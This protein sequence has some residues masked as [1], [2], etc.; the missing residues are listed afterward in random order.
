MTEIERVA[1]I[2]RHAKRVLF[3]TGAGL[4]ADSGLP[5]YRGVGGLY[6]DADTPDGLPIEAVLSGGMFRRDPALVWKH[7]LEIERACRG[8]RPNR[9]HE[10]IA[11][12]QDQAEV[13]VL[14]QNVD[15]LHRTAGS[16]DM[17][18][19]HGRVDQ[20]TCTVC[21][22]REERDDY[23]GLTFHDGVVRCPQCGAVVRPEV[24]LFDEMLPNG[25]IAR[26]EAEL[27]RGFD[28][29]V[30]VGT[31]SGFPYISAPVLFQAAAGRPAVEINPGLTDVSDEV[32][33]RLVGR[34]APLLDELWQ[35]CSA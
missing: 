3:V 20:L 9:G 14:T 4:S 21:E 7:I 35:R 23:A 34:A 2:L 17:I 26:L 28:L 32:T 25:A 27:H 6:E 5:T 11:A 1:E 16:R 30:S 22:Y 13:L 29:V 15:G 18:E 8:A 24:V 12:L 10:V 19:I 31:S 33:H